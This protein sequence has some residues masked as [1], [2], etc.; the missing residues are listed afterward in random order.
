[1]NALA[2]Q[3]SD[4]RSGFGDRVMKVN[5]AGE[6]GAV[7]IY[8]GQ[9]FFARWTAPRL[10]DELRH[11]QLHEQGHRA[12]FAA[13]LVRRAHPRCRSYLLCGLGGLALGLITG[14]LG[15]GAIAATTV[16]VESVVLRHLREQ[17]HLLGGSDP[18]AVAAIASIVAEESQHHDDSARHLQQGQFWPRI[19]AP[20]VSLS[21]EAVIWTGMRL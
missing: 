19:L 5:H 12:T 1:M 7:N 10:V 21:T 15:R 3:P 18:M 6:N 13:E 8:R 11:F 20:I 16:A 9:I 4:A 17:I 2:A 14:L